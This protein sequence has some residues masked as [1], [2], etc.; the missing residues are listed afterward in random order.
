MAE[1]C[2]GKVWENDCCNIK[3]GNPFEE[4]LR[5]RH[6]QMQEHFGCAVFYA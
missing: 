3:M 1:G 4:L 2:F 5:F 6:S